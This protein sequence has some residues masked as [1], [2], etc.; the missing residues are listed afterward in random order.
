MSSA[1]S[2]T[3]EYSGLTPCIVANQHLSQNF[4]FQDTSA[5]G[6]VPDPPSLFSHTG[7]SGDE[8]KAIQRTLWNTAAW[9]LDNLR[10][11]PE[12]YYIIRYCACSLERSEESLAHQCI[13]NFL[14]WRCALQQY[15]FAASALWH[16]IIFH[17]ATMQKQDTQCHCV[18]TVVSQVSAHSRAS[19]HVPH[20]Q[21][22]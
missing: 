14:A 9:A 16:N 18:I 1:C 19:A 12:A 15:D 22:I 20:S 13:T 7:G 21:V 8:T 17:L 11:F 6:Y 3:F 4:C 5:R 2:S 10:E